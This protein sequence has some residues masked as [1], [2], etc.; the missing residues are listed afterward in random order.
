MKGKPDRRLL[1]EFF[2]VRYIGNTRDVPA[3]SF[4]DHTGVIL[5]TE[6]SIRKIQK[7][8]LFYYKTVRKGTPTLTSPYVHGLFIIVSIK[9]IFEKK[10]VIKGSI[11]KSDLV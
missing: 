9:Q 7:R 2:A 11:R 6:G 4:H 1:V 8:A 10:R 3:T 5:E